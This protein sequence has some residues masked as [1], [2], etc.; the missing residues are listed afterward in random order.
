MKKL[1]TL[2]TLLLCVASSAWA[3]EVTAS[4]LAPS[5]NMDLTGNTTSASLLSVSDGTYSSALKHVAVWGKNN[6]YYYTFDR[7][8]NTQDTKGTINENRYVDFVATV[9]TGYR[10]TL[11][12]IEA[13]GIGVGTGNNSWRVDYYKPGA[14]TGTTIAPAA[15]LGSGT[16][17]TASIEPSTD[18]VY[19]EGQTIKVRVYVG[20]NNTSS[21]KDVGLRDIKI[22]GTSEVASTDPIPASITT[23]PSDI[24]AHVGIEATLSVEATGYPAPEYQWYSCDDTEKTNAKEIDGATSAS[25]SFTPETTG[26][27]YFYVIVQNENNTVPEV[28]NVATVTVT[29]AKAEAPTFTVYGNTVQLESATDDATI[30]Y[31]LDNPDVK[32]SETKVEYTGAFIPASSG[33]VYA[34]AEKAGFTASD[35]SSKAV[36]LST[37]GDVVGGLLATVQAAK[38]AETT[39]FGAITVTSP[40][41]PA[42][43]GRGVYPDHMKVSGT[44]T[45]T[46]SS[47]A[48]IQSIKIYGTSNDGSKVATITAGSGATVLSSPAELMPRD[49]K[50][51]ETQAMT[52]IVITVDEPAANN[53]VSF[54]LGRESRLYV[55]VYGAVSGTIT[56]AGWSTFA[57]SYPLDLSTLNA[58]SGATAYYASDA[59]GSTVTLT[60]TTA[61]V[62]P[63]EGIMVKGTAGETFTIGVAASGTA[64][65]GNLLKGQTTTG[66]VTASTTGAYHYVFGYQ[67]NDA[68]VYGFYNLT[69]DTNVEAGKAYLE[70][71]TELAAGARSLSIVFDDETTGIENLTPALSEGDGAVYN[72]S[73]QRVAQPTKGL[74]IVNGKKVII[75]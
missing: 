71:G 37:V 52:E 53:S 41:S 14:S 67:T 28:S 7:N 48:T 21:N 15:Q 34:Y 43:D 57:S 56:P 36:T 24:E 1:F 73:G 35:V 2:L 64:I 13:V 12:K 72:L 33:T 3:D 69:S 5:S 51:G 74:Y 49:V 18:N 65:D 39:T 25:Y 45:L 27:L 11:S 55:E 19:E 70:T 17:S 50:V 62:Q 22:I 38:N 32:T 66:K 10:F 59:T 47:N 31:E 6:T 63:G 9:P 4:W 23:Q 16:E 68:S 54:T 30:Y 44:V 8:D 40:A 46:A 20:I 60:S 26:I 42:W 61:T 29:A 75:K 58:T